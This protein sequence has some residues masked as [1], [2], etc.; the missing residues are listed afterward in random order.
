M[1]TRVEREDVD[2]SMEPLGII[3][4]ASCFYI[5]HIYEQTVVAM[6]STSIRLWWSLLYCCLCTVE[7][8]KEY[9]VYLLCWFLFPR[10]ERRDVRPQ[11]TNVHQQ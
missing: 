6:Y 7:N 2:G 5:S 8:L 11:L 3:L 9:E 10:D 4:S 1:E